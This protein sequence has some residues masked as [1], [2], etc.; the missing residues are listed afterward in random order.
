MCVVR[1]KKIRLN[2][3]IMYNL[4][5]LDA[6][7]GNNV[8]SYCLISAKTKQDMERKVRKLCE[9]NPERVFEYVHNMTV[10]G[11]TENSTRVWILIITDHELVGKVSC[12]KI[13]TDKI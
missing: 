9:K 13:K 5:S 7:D 8:S 4:I 11:D 2:Y 12:D 1:L 3:Y 10:L 6:S